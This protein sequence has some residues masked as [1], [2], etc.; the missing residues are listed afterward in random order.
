MR[1]DRIIAVLARI[2]D[3]QAAFDN[4]VEGALGFNMSNWF[5]TRGCGTVACLAG[6]AAAMKGWTPV[7][8]TNNYDSTVTHLV[9]KG[10]KKKG[11]FNRGRRILGLTRAEAHRVFYLG[12]LEQVY[13][14]FA[15]HLEISVAELEDQVA[16][17]RQPVTV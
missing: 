8:G 5:S 16:A 11:A 10:E 13:A 15:R 1:K 12:S 14:W 17:Q 3:E 9:T 4:H 6:H 2:E 7:F